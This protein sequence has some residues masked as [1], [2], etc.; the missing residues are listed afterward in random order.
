[1]KPTTITFSFLFIFSFLSLSVI[2]QDSTDLNVELSAKRQGWNRLALTFDVASMTVQPTKKYREYFVLPTLNAEFQIWQNNLLAFNTRVGYFRNL[3]KD[4]LRTQTNSVLG[5]NGLIGKKKHHIELGLNGLMLSGLNTNGFS[6]NTQDS[7]TLVLNYKERALY[8]MPTIGYK[9]DN[10]KSGL[11]F[12]VYYSPLILIKDFNKG[13]DFTKYE[14]YIDI[15]KLRAV[16][17]FTPF[18]VSIGY[19]FNG[20]NNL[21]KSKKEKSDLDSI[22]KQSIFPSK[23]AL[24]RFAFSSEISNY[25]G[26]K[27]LS[28]LKREFGNFTTNIEYAFKATLKYYLNARIGLSIRSLIHQT[29]YRSM[30]SINGINAGIGTKNHH[31]EIGIYGAYL[32]TLSSRWFSPMESSTQNGT[33]IENVKIF[34][35]AIYL[36]PTIG[37]RFDKFTGGLVLKVQYS[38]LLVLHDFWNAD[39]FYNDVISKLNKVYVGPS[40]N[41]KDQEEYFQ[42]NYD[43]ANP[44]SKSNFSMFQLSVGYRFKG[45]K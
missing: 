5:V 2:A 38:P 12:K 44:Y 29:N 14:K 4:D 16:N 13:T 30:S 7:L 23:F 10:T 36:M 41:R 40:E 42:N 11:I 27:S 28:Y 34:N 25:E 24:R 15:N 22:S 21:F 19:R 33:V 37:Y 35:E 3:S 45:E 1:M 43:G 39:R 20:A 6:V 9:Y 17:N 32:R 8:F 18:Q 26:E 31:L